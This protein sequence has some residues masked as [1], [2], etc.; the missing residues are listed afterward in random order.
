[1]SDEEIINIFFE[2]KRRHKGKYKVFIIKNSR[3]TKE[4]LYA[5]ANYTNTNKKY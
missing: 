1:M 2:N 5:G 4:K 3:I